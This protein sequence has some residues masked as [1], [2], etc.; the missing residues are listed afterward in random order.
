MYKMNHNDNG[1]TV[2]NDWTAVRVNVGKLWVYGMTEREGYERVRTW[3]IS[4]SDIRI[5]AKSYLSRKVYLNQKCFLESNHG[6]VDSCYK[7]KIP[8][9]HIN[10]HFE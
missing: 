7:S 6:C 5:H 1:Q 9:V 3:D 8:E 2:L 10:L 4:N